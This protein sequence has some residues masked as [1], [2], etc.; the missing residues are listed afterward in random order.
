MGAFFAAS[1]EGPAAKE[2]PRPCRTVGSELLVTA[3]AWARVLGRAISIHFP[4]HQEG[5]LPL[6]LVLTDSDLGPLE[7]SP[8]PPPAASR[9][10]QLRHITPRC[11]WGGLDSFSQVLNLSFPAAHNPLSTSASGPR[12]SRCHRNTPHRMLSFLWH[13]SS[14]AEAP[15]PWGG[16]LDSGQ[17]QGG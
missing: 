16:W 9:L 3:R 15:G 12:C 13:I 6:D 4:G 2:A 1:P 5:D 17:A 10:L 14:R 7:G 8:P 11:A